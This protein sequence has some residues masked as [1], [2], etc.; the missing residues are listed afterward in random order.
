[1]ILSLALHRCMVQHILYEIL[2]LFCY[3]YYLLLLTF[4]FPLFPRFDI[5]PFTHEAMNVQK[6]Y[7]HLEKELENI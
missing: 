2:L 3:L 6:V 5:F 4:T 1:M 7:F